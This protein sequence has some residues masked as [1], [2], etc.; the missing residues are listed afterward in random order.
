MDGE[1]GIRS[2]FLKVTVFVLNLVILGSQV[3]PLTGKKKTKEKK[4]KQI[5]LVRWIEENKK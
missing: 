5:W 4:R 1:F 3:Q 2:F